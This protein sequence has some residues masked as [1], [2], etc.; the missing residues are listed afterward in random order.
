MVLSADE[1]EAFAAFEKSGWEKAAEA[2]H[3]HWGALSSQSAVAMLDAAGVF[4]GTKVLDVCTGAGYV[5]AKAH[6]R[7][8]IAKGLDFSTAQVTLAS[9][10][11][12]QVDFVE[13]DAQNLP[14]EDETF[15]GV[16]MGFG[17]N[18][19]PDP[20]KA[21]LEAWRVLKPGGKFAFTVW[22]KP[23][24]AD[25]FG[26]VLKSI[27]ANSVPNSDLPPAPP[28]FRFADEREI[29]DLLEGA[30]FA[31][32]TTS[33]VPQIWRHKSPDHVFDAFNEG[34]VRATAMLRS[35]PEHI[36]EI[37]RQEVR[38]SVEQLAV[39][40]EFHIPLPAALSVGQKPK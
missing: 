14:F 9:R 36:R 27:D 23:G 24:D 2:Y 11:F 28:Y 37:I 16:V 4:P 18:Y 6:E 17:M 20:S 26:I 32:V 34:A 31:G 5:A 13:G 30:G 38:A 35:Q 39:G 15:D 33:I 40:E 1:T 21:T 29:L 3:D 25:G 8:A 7:G 22:A 10:V 19:L 12:P